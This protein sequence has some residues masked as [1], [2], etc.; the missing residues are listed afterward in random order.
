MILQTIN[1]AIRLGM[2]CRKLYNM[3]KIYNYLDEPDYAYFLKEGT[4]YFEVKEKELYKISGKNLIVAAGEVLL[5]YNSDNY[6]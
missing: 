1:S 3:K 5:N 2:L 4:V 6:F